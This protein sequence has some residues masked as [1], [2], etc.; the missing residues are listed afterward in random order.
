MKLPDGWRIIPLNQVIHTLQAGVSVNSLDEEVQDLK[1]IGILKTSSVTTGR[2]DPRENKVVVQ[3]DIGRVK[4]PVQGDRIILSR[5]NT[6]CLVGANTYVPQDHP[7]LFLPDRLWSLEPLD[8]SICMRWLSFVLG[9]SEYRQKLSELATGTSNSMKNISKDAVMALE[10]PY[11]PLPE[12][13]RIAEFLGTWDEAIEK[14]ERLIAAKEKR[15]RGLIQRSLAFKKSEHISFSKIFDVISEKNQPELPLLSVTQNNGVIPRDMLEGRVWSPE[16]S[17]EGYKVVQKNDFVVSLRSF[18]GGLEYS[19]FTGLI[20]PAYTVLRARKKVAYEFYRFFFKSYIFI[21]Q[22]LD[23][24][25]IGIRDGKQISIPDLLTIAIPFPD[26]KKQK[27][28]AFELG[29]NEKEINLLK[30]KI[31]VLQKQKRGL[32]QKLLTGTW[33]V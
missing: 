22:Y 28:I 24:A 11:P 13:R 33:R 32:M 12:Q 1:Q 4:T 27:N 31:A 23:L 3:K 25:V 14:L 9:S 15:F 20:S 29:L 8:A 5:M 26:I 2:F 7:N 21:H 17:L 18:Q 30:K 16:G 10:I 19:L 6:P